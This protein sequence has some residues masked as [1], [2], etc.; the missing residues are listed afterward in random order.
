VFAF[1]P[2]AA[3]VFAK[4][5]NMTGSRQ[6]VQRALEARGHE[7]LS[8]KGGFWL[9]GQGF[10]S[11]AKARQM[12]GITAKPRP[13]RPRQLPWGDYATAAALNGQLKG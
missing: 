1:Q 11:L 2:G 8:G 12:T 5:Q 3:A 4:G 7:V 9:H 6:D 10:V 13:R